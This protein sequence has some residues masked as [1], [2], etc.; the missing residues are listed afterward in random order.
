MTRVL[1]ASRD[2][3]FSEDI[4]VV[5]LGH[6]HTRASDLLDLGLSLLGEELRLHDRR[7]ARKHTLAQHLEVSLWVTFGQSPY[8]S[9]TAEPSLT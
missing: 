3:V 5:A 6:K 7:L 4:Y 9:R 2:K 8:E 1:N